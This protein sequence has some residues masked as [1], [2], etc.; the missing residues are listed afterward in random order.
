MA[1]EASVL[2][3]SS[4]FGIAFI[5]I[6]PVCIALAF[7]GGFVGVV[8]GAILESVIKDIPKVNKVQRDV[9]KVTV[10]VSLAIIFLIIIHTVFSPESMNFRKANSY[11]IKTDLGEIAKVVDMSTS[12]YSYKISDCS[13]FLEESIDFKDPT[14]A[15]FQ[16]GSDNIEFY[17]GSGGYTFYNLI[18]GEKIK[19][20]LNENYPYIRSISLLPIENQ[21][22]HYLFILSNLRATSE[23]SLLTV[24]KYP[25]QIVYEELIKRDKVDMILGQGQKTNGDKIITLSDYLNSSYS[26]TGEYV[27]Y[28]DLCAG[29]NK[30]LNNENVNNNLLLKYLYKIK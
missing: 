2:P 24:Y 18:T 9:R 11:G 15:I 25:R 21:G 6:I 1:F 30:L 7:I 10:M 19:Y 17:F 5:F 16:W 27:G 8:I 22:E 14:N 13:L 12:S 26:S 4:T 23:R 28:P 29:D 3:L 20:I